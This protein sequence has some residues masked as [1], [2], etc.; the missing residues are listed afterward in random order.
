[1][2]GKKD[3]VLVFRNLFGVDSKERGNFFYLSILCVKKTR[4][5]LHVVIAF[6]P[7]VTRGIFLLYYYKG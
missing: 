5:F 7:G 6:V 3:V 4:F 1:M 2:W